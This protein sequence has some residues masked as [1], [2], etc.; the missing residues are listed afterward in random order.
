M[1]FLRELLLNSDANR[2]TPHTLCTFF[3]P[4]L[5]RG[6]M[7][8][9]SAQLVKEERREAIQRARFIRVFLKSGNDFSP[10]ERE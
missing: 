8:T 9:N 4:I 1:S 7:P 5:L 10:K 2:L 6:P 3:A